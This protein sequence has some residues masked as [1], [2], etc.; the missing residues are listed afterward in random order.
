MQNSKKAD[1]QQPN[2]SEN[3]NHGIWT[4]WNEVKHCA[5][6]ISLP[7]LTL[8]YGIFLRLS[9]L[10]LKVEAH[11]PTHGH[12]SQ[13]Y[14]VVE[15]ADFEDILHVGHAVGHAEVPQ[16]VSHEDDVAVLLH[17]FEVLR[18]PQGTVVLVVHMDQLAFETL[19]D[20]LWS[21]EH[22][23]HREP[24]HFSS[25]EIEL[26]RKRKNLTYVVIKVH[27]VGHDLDVGVV[28]SGLADDFLQDVAQ[29]G[30]EDEDGHVVLLQ[31]VKELLKAFPENQADT[32]RDKLVTDIV[33]SSVAVN[34]AYRVCTSTL[35][36]SHQC[37]S[38]GC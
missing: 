13:L 14:L 17:L 16:W 34:K 8:V 37:F 32:E 36:H 28:D 22:T 7:S 24:L 10:Q 30:G 20:A 12:V 25:H 21:E 9:T 35:Q 5:A 26:K 11:F 19:Q 27:E 15:E 23:S 29:T 18:V 2:S 3:F 6:E 4:A 33:S 31:A 1:Q 38:S